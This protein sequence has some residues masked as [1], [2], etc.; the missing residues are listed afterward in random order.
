MNTITRAILAGILGIGL[1]Q[2]LGTSSAQAQGPI[3]SLGG[4]GGAMTDT[5][6]G[7]GMSGP[8]HSVRGEVR[9][10]HALSHGDRRQSLLP[11]AECLGDGV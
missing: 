1:G 9:R 3:G 7:A 2:V 8:D 4:F 5:G 10:L 6:S 11:A